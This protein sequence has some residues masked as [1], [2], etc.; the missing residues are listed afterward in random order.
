MTSRRRLWRVAIPALATAVILLPVTW[1]WADSLMPSAYSVMDMG[2]P[3]YGGGTTDHA[4]G[5]GHG[6]GVQHAGVHLPGMR[7]VTALTTDPHRKA[8][9]RVDLV[10]R[11]QDLRI[12]GR[13]MPGYTL[14]GSSPG[15]M[16]TAVQGQLI[17]V[18]LHN[19]SVPDGVTLHW[20]GIDVPNATD[21]VAGV[22]QDAVGVGHD[23]VYRFV[24]DHA[25]TFWYHSHQVS[26]VQ[27]IGG[28]LGP[29]VIR[30]RTPAVDV[31][32]VTAVA[33]VYSG[34]RTINGRPG[35]LGVPAPARQLVRLRVIN[36]DNGQLQVWSTLPY[37]VLAIDGRDV[38]GPTPI[39]GRVLTVPAGG[40][41]DLSLVVPATGAGRVRLGSSTSVIIGSGT[42]PTVAQPT[43]AV[44]LLHYGSPAATASATGLLF[45]PSGVD[46]RFRYDI[47]R[48]PG[49]VNGRPGLF[50]SINGHL[51]PDVPMFMV[52]E[53]EVVRMIISN[54]SG[55]VHPMHLHGHHGLVLSRNGVAATGSPWWIDSL[56]VSDGE[57]YVIAFRAD[58]PGIWMDHCHNLKHSAQGMIGHLMYAG[59]STPFMIRG[60]ND[61]QPE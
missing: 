4:Q 49:F 12:G 2:R 31:R 22:T 23:F 51:Y 55:D 14:N 43:A 50:W 24:A 47:G 6:S 30:P 8:D 57:T 20:H 44:D 35:D 36:T 34:I 59:V 53:G 17:E 28:L 38:H 1:L 46:R 60:T 27:V 56:N 32:D 37:R 25:G 40:R 58:N 19:A 48:R 29:L 13:T 16:I 54:H 39:T 10:A 3:D 42:A 7:S 9:V 18:H 45:D 11:R 21:G 41:A 61:N 33:H 52:G 15:P 26:H 5:S